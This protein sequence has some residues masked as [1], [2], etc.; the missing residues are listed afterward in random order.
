[1]SLHDSPTGADADRLLAAIVDSTEDAI[2]R[3]DLSG[4][5]LSWNRG[6][7]TMLGYTSSEMAGRS[8]GHLLPPDDDGRLDSAL[9][10]VR[11]GTPAE[12]R[13]VVMLTKDGQRIQVS[14]S[15]SPIRNADGRATGAV[16][17]ARDLTAQRRAEQA[18]RRS[19]ERWRAIIE[20][21][22]DAIVLINHRGTIEFF[23]PAA[24][25]IFGY[26]AQEV[27]GCN[28][29]MLMPDPYSSEH[30]HYLRRYQMT[31]ERRIIGIGREVTARRKDGTSFPAHLSVAELTVDGETKFTGIVRDLTERV[32]LEVRL[33]E[34]SGL[35]RIGELAA[36]L[37]HEV[38]NPL[39]AVSGAIQMLSEH[40]SAPEDQEIVQEILRRLDGLGA[41]MTDLLL[42]SRPPRPQPRSIDVGELLR[43]LT[44]F[45]KAD[46]AWE[47]V[48][49]DVQGE[50][51]E[52][53][54]DP[55]LLKVVFQNLLLNAAQAMRF[56][57]SITVDLHRSGTTAFVDVRDGGPGISPDVRGK[58][59]TPFFTTKARGTGLGLA[60]VR[61]I[62]ESHG[63][64][65][66]VLRSGH[67]GTT[68]RVSLPESAGR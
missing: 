42:Y 30:D 8:I 41:L 35:V 28:V 64:Q 39:A 9:Q 44:G 50:V 52:L 10:H 65:V 40:L 23:N 46:P 51:Q 3:H 56:D 5:I 25:R 1:M 2:I 13:D 32:S 19:E 53:W 18:L 59:F 26:P 38:K 11:E 61:R 16:M 31:G 14:V 48:R 6:A 63:G 58:L 54:A 43:A 7:Q 12:P 34:E 68:M 55:E 37:A 29:S 49:V 15:L 45:Y 62:V 22:V 67:E 57:G 36:V 66:E 20:S 17:M 60:T 27:I 21:A 33:R 4:T 47:K 24:E